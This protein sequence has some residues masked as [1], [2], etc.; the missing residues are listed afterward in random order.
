MKLHILDKLFGEI[1]DED[2][3]YLMQQDIHFQ[4][5]RSKLDSR[6]FKSNMMR[7]EMGR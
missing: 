7:K 6:V 1:Y 2:G 4:V 5:I 3:N